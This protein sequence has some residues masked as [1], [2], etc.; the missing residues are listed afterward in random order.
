M[1]EPNSNTLKSPFRGWGLYLKWAI[2]MFAY[3]FLIYKLITFTHYD[4]LFNWWRQMPLAQFWWLA[5]VFAML[6]VNWLLES[7]KWKMLTANIQKISLLTSFKAV[8]AGISTGFFTPNRVGELV[9]RVLYL[10]P[11][12]R[13][14]G[15]T[16]SLVNSLTQNLIM[17]L[18]GI[19][20]CLVYFYSTT[21]VLEVDIEN[22][23][24]VLL[25]FVVLSG[26]LYFYLPRLSKFL[27]Q[28]NIASE[29]KG[30]TVGLSV[31]TR[32]DLVRIMGV[33]LLR[34]LVFCTQFFLMLRFFGIQLQF[35]EALI[36]IPTN[37]L[38][39]TFSP[40]VA[41]SEAAIRSSYAVLII[42]AYSGQLVNIAL[43][44][45]SIWTVNFVVPML[46]GS[47]LLVKEK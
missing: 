19:P 16:M 7:L 17:A 24:L 4:Q 10:N 18:C 13:K 40:S 29:I 45:V 32:V 41:F 37:Y 44:G 12:N 47:V 1:S 46:V 35:Q 5:A 26:L 15:V 8:L 9:G 21:N 36:A 38:F 25:A 14:T 6:P 31:Y 33:S 23:I 42:G 3:S 30:F 43:A 22:F 39:V 20:A 28:T 34:Y 11:E 27:A 2:M